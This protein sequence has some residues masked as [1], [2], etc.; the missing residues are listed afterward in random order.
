MHCVHLVVL[1]VAQLPPAH[2]GQGQSKPLNPPD[3]WARPPGP[4][5]DSAVTHT[6]SATEP[7]QLYGR[8]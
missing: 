5:M 7:Q 2:R 8:N 6:H 3:L 4:F 1:L